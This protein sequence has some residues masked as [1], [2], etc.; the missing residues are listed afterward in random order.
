MESFLNLDFWICHW[1]PQ[2]L[3]P[4]QSV[5]RIQRRMADNAEALDG[6]SESTRRQI[7]EEVAECETELCNLNHLLQKHATDAKS[8]HVRR[9]CGLGQGLPSRLPPPVPGDGVRRLLNDI[10]GKDLH[11]SALASRK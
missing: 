11:M 9:E 6:E 4:Y 3:L 10:T 1:N 8:T 2:N 5:E 7:E